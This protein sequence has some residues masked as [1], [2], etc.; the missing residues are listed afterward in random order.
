LFGGSRKRYTNADAGI[1]RDVFDATMGI[2]P[3]WT[4][5]SAEVSE[6]AIEKV[7]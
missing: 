4:Q 7:V 3:I 5:E 2:F 1:N 6:E